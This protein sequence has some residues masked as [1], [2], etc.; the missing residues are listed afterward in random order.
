MN[1]FRIARLPHAK[2]LPLPAYKTD[3][4][5]GMDI[6]A[7]VDKSTII[8][9]GERAII[10]TGLVI[11]LPPGYEAQMRPRSGLAY[12]HGVTTLNAPGTIDADYRGELSVLLINHGHE[13]FVIER[14]DRIAQFVINR[15]EQIAWTEQ[16]FIDPDETKRGSKGYGST[17]VDQH[18]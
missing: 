14:G 2:D 11:A 16:D 7:C 1:Q 15:I 8:G 9:P 18:E 13:S 5:A 10:K 6:C 17:G 12:K 3:L 4:A